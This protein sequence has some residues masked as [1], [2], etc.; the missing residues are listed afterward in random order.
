M[1]TRREK[2]MNPTDY[3]MHWV[4][5]AAILLTLGV[6]F[7]AMP[8]LIPVVA[9]GVG[10]WAVLRY[11]GWAGPIWSALKTALRI[12]VGIPIAVFFWIT[13]V[14]YIVFWKPLAYFDIW[15]ADEGVEQ[16]YMAIDRGTNWV[17]P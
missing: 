13:G 1:A 6:L 7:V 5:W 9:I 2:L 10:V 4:K 11:T 12:L 16:G 8:A 14:F 3:P 17:T 15:R